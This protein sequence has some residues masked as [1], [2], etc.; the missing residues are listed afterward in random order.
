MLAKGQ[1]GGLVEGRK[2]L[3]S[4][5]KERGRNYLQTIS[6]PGIS[7]R[8]C[9]R[10]SAHISFG[11]LSVRQVEHETSEKMNA[12]S[13]Q[14]GEDAQRFLRNL[15]AF[16]SRLAW[17]C[18]FVQKLESQPEIE[19]QCMHPAFEGMREPYFRQDY[20]DAWCEGQTGYPVIDAAM[21]S[22][23]DNGWITFRMR[24]MLVSFASYHLWLD[25]RVT[26][27]YLAR[28]FTDY[29]PGIH[30]SQFQMQSGVTGIN[31]IRMYNP[32]KQ[33]LDHDPDGRF[34]RRYVPE[35]KDVSSQWVHQ[36]WRMPEPP[37]AYP[38]PV[39]DHDAALQ[40]ARRE[41]SARW[42]TDGFKEQA[43]AVHSRL[44]SRASKTERS[45]AIPKPQKKPDRQLTFD[46]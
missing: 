41:L 17:R 16:R 44:G 6:K 15:A 12:L 42:K 46:L 5:L 23:I 40:H 7:A 37:R 43:Q 19:T 8:H 36:P 14:P 33:S 24:A 39:V 26:A 4:F 34:I 3:D 35:L 29:E 2:V 31:A 11:S 20:F 1:T 27:P 45:R 21:R 28:L 38:A 32:V 18:H 22:L 25:W 30:Y 10:L 13:D 9:S